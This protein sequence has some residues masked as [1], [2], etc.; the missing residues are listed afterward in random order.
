MAT[1]DRLAPPPS[2]PLAPAWKPRRA[3]AVALI[4][5]AAIAL[6]QVFQSGSSVHTGLSLQRLER[7]QA[8]LTASVHELEAQVAALSSL[9]RVERAARERLGFVPAKSILYLEVA[10]EAP[11]GLLGP[12]PSIAAPAAAASESEAVPW[13]RDLLR[14]TPFD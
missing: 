5:A 3:I 8:D 6:L 13:W 9:D 11:G 14:A 10:T 1:L 7:Q 4:A 12:P 2:A